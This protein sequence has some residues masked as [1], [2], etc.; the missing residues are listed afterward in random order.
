M[1]TISIG[2]LFIIFFPRS[3]QTP[4][5]L[6][7]IRYFSDKEMRIILERVVRDDPSKG[8]T[9]RSISK[10]EIWSTAT[11]WRLIAH[12]VATVC[13]LAPGSALMA[14][15][16]RL[17]IEWGYGRLQSNAMVS[18]GPSIG[19]LLC[20]AWG[21][22]ADRFQKRG[23]VALAG[24]FVWWLFLLIGRLLVYSD[25]GPA[26]FAAFAIAIA[27]QGTWHPVNGSWMALNAP[28]AG[29]RSITM[30]ILIMSANSAG[31]IGG[32]LFQSG[33]APLYPIG[34][35]AIVCLTSVALLAMVGANV[36][37]WVLNRRLVKKGMPK[38]YHP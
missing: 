7:G 9:R 15:G 34:W 6:T 22:L 20:I 29:E 2:I 8:N 27:F 19:L 11:N 17:V 31:I 35:T 25:N 3:V 4:S 32:Q 37:Y 18:I 13:G 23:A 26:H 14:Y 16:P 5:S 1:F 38:R 24:L 33:D 10:A 36:Q 30:A 21:M 28:T 12:V